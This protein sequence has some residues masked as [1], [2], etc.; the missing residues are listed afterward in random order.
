MGMMI[1][2]VI[3]AVG[4][5]VGLLSGLVGIGGG[6]L[7]V[8]FL[9]FFYDRPDL[10]G[11][12]VTPEA[13]ITMAHATS[14]FVITPTAIRGA[15]S[16]HRAGLVDWKVVWPIATVS[17]FAA[18]G[19]GALALVLPPEALKL[20]LGTLLILAGIRLIYP[21]SPG[22]AA[23]EAGAPAQMTLL[24]A[25]VAGVLIGLFSAMLGVGG[26]I[27]GIPLLIYMLKLDV[28]RVAATS[29]GIVTLTS[30]AG[31]I[32]YMIYGYGQ[33][34]L[35]SGS[36]GYVHVTVGLLLIIGSLIS[37]RWGTLINQAM[38]PRALE[39]LFGALFIISG[40]RIA[41]GNLLDLLAPH[42]HA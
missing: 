36:I 26:G 38:K 19:G 7:I 15:L 30:A 14:L 28:R 22:K 42:I 40:L 29:I 32:S 11:A 25:V 20:G 6:A 33:P 16:Y 35:P 3:I 37:V 23:V 39:I 4:I 21:S 17:V 10:F 8:P 9:Y 41:G 18:F 5:A 2:V 31:A 34:G 27:V 13:R 1:P 24:R 12:M